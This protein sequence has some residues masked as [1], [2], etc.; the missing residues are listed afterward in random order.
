MNFKKLEI[1]NIDHIKYL[2][3]KL[4]NNQFESLEKIIE[5]LN[6]KNFK[7]PAIQLLYANSKALKKNSN[8]EDK[9]IA[10]DIF[11]EIYKSNPSF[12]NALYNACAICFQIDEYN[13]IL[14]L[15]E[16]FIR[17]GN[18]DKKIYSTLYKI[19]AVLGETEKTHKILELV[20]KKEPENLKAW[21]ALIFNSLYLDQ[22][23]QNEN[24]DLYKKFSNNITNHKIT[25]KISISKKN[26]K[27]KIGFISPY[28]DGNSIDGFLLGLL[29]NMDRK[30]F[31]IIG[32]NLN[33][34][35]NKSKHL[36]NY[37]D[38]W[39]HV[40]DLKDIDLINFIR[41]K[42]INILIDLVG[43]GPGNRLSVIKN[44]VAPIQISWLGYT[45]TT[46]LKEMDYIIADPN[47]IEENEHNLY[48]EKILYL[49]NIWNSHKEMDEKLEIKNLPYDKNNHIT[50]GSFNNFKKIS[51]SVIKVWSQ[52]LDETNSKLILKSSMHNN[53][54]LRERFLNKF[55]KSLTNKGKI[56]L[57]EGQ[58]KK[59]DHINLYNEVDI[60][61]DTFPYTGVTTTFEAIWMGVP[62]LT[63][64]GNNFSSRCGESININ[65]KLEQ[66]I[67]KDTDDY[68]KKAINFTKEI[69]H[70][71]NLRK[72][73]RGDAKNS[74]L[75]KTKNFAIQ[76]CN[77]LKNLWLKK[78][79]LSKL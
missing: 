43:H 61:L 63:L 62:V 7:H 18:Y 24:S 20:V 68:I 55:P 74:P 26:S 45:N 65:L 77:E 15:L 29:E 73:L 49:P 3:N 52:I 48:Y 64:K 6:K 16:D 25:E 75:F 4:L 5:N 79:N 21:S 2:E 38:S 22:F 57:L 8:L 39:H 14:M 11:I 59:L 33:I 37:F 60:G 35:N 40:H 17:K 76:F 27:I 41:R 44:R 70:I 56:I 78:Q 36:I 19:Y 32:F 69:D 54:E 9:K 13:E 34:S 42:N 28:F 47:L 53:L 58:K 12:I 72:S 46:G 67:A 50:F 10:F 1:I 31:E 23:V 66:F 30:T 71:R 51:N